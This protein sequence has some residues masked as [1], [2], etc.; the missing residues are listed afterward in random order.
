M[1]GAGENGHFLIDLGAEGSGHGIHSLEDFLVF[2]ALRAALGENGSSEGG[3][4][5]A[6]G[7]V[8]GGTGV[9]QEPESD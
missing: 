9:K 5:F 2:E 8:I 1:R 7:G 6:T 4:T 3:D